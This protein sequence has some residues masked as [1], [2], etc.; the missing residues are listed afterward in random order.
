MN[1]TTFIIILLLFTPIF[2]SFGQNILSKKKH[3]ISGYIENSGSKEKLIGTN[4]YDTTNFS[5][6]ISNNYGFYSLTYNENKK[7]FL[8]YSF[9]GFQ[10]VIHSFVLTS[11][12]VINILLKP[13]LQLEEITVYGE[14]SMVESAQTGLIK[15]PIKKVEQLPVILGEKDLLKTFQLFPGVQQGLE[16]TCGINVRG[17]SPDQNLF[18]IDDVP[19]YNINHLFGVF[20]VINS[21]AIKDAKLIKGGFPARYYGRI[22]SVLDIHLK[23]GNLKHFQAKGSI[24]LLSSSLTLEGPIKKDTSSFIVSARR[25]YFDIFTASLAKLSNGGLS[26]YYFQDLNAKYNYKFSDKSNL[27]LSIYTGADKYYVKNNDEN[28]KI[29]NTFGWGNLISSLRW[30]YKLSNKIFSNTALIFSRY[31]FF[32]VNINEDKTNSDGNFNHTYDN[33]IFDIGIKSDI[34]YY[35]NPSNKI[36]FGFKLSESIFK[37]QE[38]LC[39]GLDDLFMID[40]SYN[41]SNI[42]NYSLSFYAENN[43]KINN[44]ITSNIGIRNT[45]FFVKKKLFNLFEPRLSLRYLIT[46][47][48]SVK[49]AYSR[50]NQFIHLLSLSKIS[51]PTDLWMPTTD[52]IKPIV[53]DQYVVGAYYAHKNYEFS[54][55]AYYKT[56]NNLIEYKEGASYFDVSDW[57]SNIE[58][59]SGL[60]YGIEFLFKKNIGNTSGWL[61]YTLSKS[62]RT[63]KNLNRGV[64]FPYKYDRRHYINIVLTHKINDK[65]NFGFTWIYTTGSAFTLETCKYITY[66]A[67]YMS[68]AQYRSIRVKNYE[69]NN[70]RMPAY[71]RLD[72]NINFMKKKKWGERTWSVGIINAYNHQNAFDIEYEEDEKL[73]QYSILPIMPFIRYNFKF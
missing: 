2:N 72:F 23:E 49:F 41:I 43:I 62:T 40:T 24:G 36:K 61:S 13:N 37:P 3:T 50:M 20:S 64:T 55:E 68:N 33:K 7:L 14:K 19:V 21:D 34:D 46:N 45:L 4:I 16:G 73:F 6:T 53:S 39:K 8:K 60:A 65:I 12:T 18:L 35:L 11:D 51:L 31:K 47:K 66:A 26:G 69:K 44:K 9:I 71:Q 48:L 38:K 1:K 28:T 5:G 25:S 67:N 70:F 15:M 10:P 54:V 63:F 30:N 27:Y 56:M 32:T 42:N 22:S 58:M 17:G 59:G 29:K 57:E 52:S